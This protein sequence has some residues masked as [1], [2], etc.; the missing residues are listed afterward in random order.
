VNATKSRKFI[1]YHKI[2]FIVEG[3]LIGVNMPLTIGIET[4]LQKDQILQHGHT[5]SV[6]VDA[7]FGTN[8]KKVLILS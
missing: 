1:Y 6:C 2:R 8:E 7:I 5:N 3:Q 4:P